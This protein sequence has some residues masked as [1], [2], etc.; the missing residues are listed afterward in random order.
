MYNVEPKGLINLCKTPLENDYK[1]QLTFSNLESQINYFNSVIVKSFSE[2]TYIRTD[3]SIK[4]GANILPLFLNKV[5][6][7]LFFIFMLYLIKIKRYRQKYIK[8]HK[9]INKFTKKINMLKYFTI[10][11]NSIGG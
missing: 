7:R 1:N 5:Y 10:N 4:V 11:K 6:L 2:Y 3:N 8:N 9:I